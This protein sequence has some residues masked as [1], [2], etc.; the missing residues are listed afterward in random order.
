[1]DDILQATLWNSLLCLKLLEL[2]E[3]AQKYVPQIKI[4]IIIIDITDHKSHYFLY[5]YSN[6]MHYSSWVDR[7]HLCPQNAFVYTIICSLQ[8]IL[9]FFP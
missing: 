7:H 8:L 6:R 3:I 5:L 1:M 9:F 2:V 4:I